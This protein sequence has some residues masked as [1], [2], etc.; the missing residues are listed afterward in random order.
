[1]NV[2]TDPEDQR[3]SEEDLQVETDTEHQSRD[4]K[5]TDPHTP[6]AHGRLVLTVDP[7]ETRIHR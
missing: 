3:R 4:R 6:A 2:V 5:L 1:M 7:Q